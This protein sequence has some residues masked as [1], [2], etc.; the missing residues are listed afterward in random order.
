MHV[1]AVILICLLCV[2]VDAQFQ[3]VG[4]TRYIFPR[5]SILK[6][7]KVE[8]VFDRSLNVT[9]NRA[10]RWI[11]TTSYWSSIA[12]MSFVFYRFR[13][14]TPSSELT[15]PRMSLNSP[16]VRIRLETADDA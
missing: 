16:L 12:T 3:F 14:N 4:I 6:D 8:M 9:G 7:L 11:T 13:D 1:V 15:G 5:C 10:T 2:I